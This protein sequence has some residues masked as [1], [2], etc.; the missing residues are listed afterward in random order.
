VP[1]LRIWVMRRQQALLPIFPWGHVEIDIEGEL[2]Y[3]TRNL[4]A[5]QLT[6]E[7]TPPQE[8]VYEGTIPARSE[9]ELASEIERLRRESKRFPLRAEVPSPEADVYSREISMAELEGLRS[10]LCAKAPYYR[11]KNEAEGMNCVTFAANVLHSSGVLPEGFRLESFGTPLYPETF[12]KAMERLRTDS[13]FSVCD[14]RV[15]DGV[16][17]RVTVKQVG[18]ST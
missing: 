7:G 6:P 9:D 16:H 12:Y 18:G 15:L 1:R 17:W 4:D 3:L 10:L 14:L 5:K 13:F 8:A 11:A 2:F